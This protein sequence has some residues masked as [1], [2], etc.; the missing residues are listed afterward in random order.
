VSLTQGC[1][2]RGGPPSSLV[3]HEASSYLLLFTYKCK[4][5]TSHQ[6]HWLDRFFKWHPVSVNPSIAP[7]DA[8][9]QLYLHL[10]LPLPLTA[11]L[12]V[13]S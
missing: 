12:M 5:Y 2:K 1:Y 11:S 10:L 3:P 4:T 6:I 7:A 8:Y 9:L 13:K